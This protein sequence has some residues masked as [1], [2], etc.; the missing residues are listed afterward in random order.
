VDTNFWHQRWERNEIAFH[1][2][3]A[4][5][6]LV[7]YFDVLSLSKGSRVFLPLCGKTLD[8]HWLLSNGYRVVGSELSEVAVKQLFS[9]LAIEPKITAID[10]IRR[11]S[12]DNI[13]I[14]VGDIFDL[15]RSVLA[16]VDAIYDRAALV[17]LPEAMRGRY[18]AHLIKITDRAPQLLISYDYDQ[19][20]VDGP[21]FSVSNEEVSR[22]KDQGGQRWFH[23]YPSE[24]IKHDDILHW[25]KLNQNWNFMCSE[26]HSTGVQKNYDA[27]T[28]RFHTTWSEISVGCET[29]HGQGSRHV[30]WVK[31]QSWWPFG[32]HE[33]KTE[34]LVV[35]FDERRGITWRQDPK[36]GNPL[37]N[38]TPPLLRK[39]VETCGLCHARRAEFSEDWVPGQWLSDTHVVSELSH[40][41]YFA[42]GQ[43]QDEVY[44]YGPLSRARCSRR[45]SHAVTVT[46]RTATN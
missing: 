45:A 15:S 13:D 1:Q 6:L 17:A 19:S 23:L 27:N 16:R 36:T 41:L 37:R 42:D 5:P 14:F 21:P 46:T 2:H 8:I 28:D 33:D 4:N 12:A 39:E 24:E 3:E 22:P 18:A 40:G 34:G 11:H 43:M 10:D 26:C 7:K 35:R 38:F 9:E 31:D 25:T 29:C 30:A 44:N 32:K 20:L